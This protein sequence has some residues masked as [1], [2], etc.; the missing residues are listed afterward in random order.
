M[1][2]WIFLVTVLLTAT[3]AFGTGQSDILGTWKTDGGDSLLEFF[4]CGDK[5]CGKI[6]W[7][8]APSY[9]DRKDGPVGTIKVDRK[10]PNPA[11]RTR[12]V[13]GLEV[14]KGLTPKG[15]NRWGNG[16]CYDPETGKSYKCKMYLKSPKRME[17]RGYIGISLI[18]RTFA[19]TR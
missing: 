5:I 16:A 14:M 1:K 8:K 18:G 4:K 9:I 17:L 13:L 3:T 19:L 7:L 10:N 11:L 12:P 6:V 2:V 15:A